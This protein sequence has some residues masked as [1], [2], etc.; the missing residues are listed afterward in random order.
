MRAKTMG[1]I[2]L[3]A[4]ILALATAVAH[5][6]Q[7]DGYLGY[8]PPDQVLPLPLGSNHPEDG[9]FYTG[10][11]FLFFRQTVPI[12]DQ[13]VATRG[14]YNI[15]SQNGTSADFVGSG[16]VALNTEQVRGPG[17][18]DPGF[19]L[20]A[21]WKF[22]DGSVLTF[23]W[24]YLFQ[25]RFQAVATAAP[26]NLN[27]RQDFADSFITAPVFNFPSEFAGLPQQATGPISSFNN[28]PTAT[29]GVW[30]GASQMTES[31][32]QR[33]SAFDL[34]WRQSIWECENYRLSSLLGPKLFWIWETYNWRTTNFAFG[35]A[36]AGESSSATY[37]NDI[38]NRLYGFNIGCSQEWYIGH[39]LAC[40]LDTSVTPDIDFVRE[41]V[42]YRNGGIDIGAA[43]NKRSKRD[44]TPSV[45]LEAKFSVSYYPWEFVQLNFGYNIMTFFNTITSE[46]PIDFNYSS[47]T[48]AYNH[49]YLRVMDGL[50]ASV[51]FVF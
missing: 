9:G 4:F 31:F 1:R 36:P 23:S 16:T 15:N 17:T 51:I 24:L 6:Q 2:G 45:E 14:F 12:K 47:L 35:N 48:P 44:Y 3:L 10:M 37:S 8:A 42:M 18:Y 11:E 40:Q 19:K 39:G 22:D 43:E 49:D 30:D 27:V 34:I 50:S 26:P 29:Y 32:I 38:S 13:V 7:P 28:L 33:T 25:N 41:K 5:A 46:L 20:Y 21:G